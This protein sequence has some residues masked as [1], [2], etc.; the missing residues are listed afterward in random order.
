MS[1]E[2]CEVNI[3][4]SEDDVKQLEFFCRTDWTNLN[5]KL[6]LL[7]MHAVTRPLVWTKGL[8]GQAR[9]R[10][11]CNQEFFWRPEEMPQNTAKETIEPAPT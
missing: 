3:E 2:F 8:A 5:S 6:G 10:N 9:T 11:N 4:D 1:N 7:I